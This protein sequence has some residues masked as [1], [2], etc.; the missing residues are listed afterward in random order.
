MV[1]SNK[2]AMG[3][4]FPNSFDALIPDMVNVRLMASLPFASR[5]RLIDFILS[6]MSNC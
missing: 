6:S 4:I 2:S 3:I 1:V 5:Y